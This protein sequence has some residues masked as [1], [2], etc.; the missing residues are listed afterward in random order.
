M[1]AVKEL[2]QWRRD[3]IAAIN[4]DT[5]TLKARIQC[6]EKLTGLQQYEALESIADAEYNLRGDC[7]IV[8]RKMDFLN[9]HLGLDDDGL[10]DDEAIE[11][12]SRVKPQASFDQRKSEVARIKAKRVHNRIVERVCNLCGRKDHEPH[13]SSCNG[14]DQRW[15]TR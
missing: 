8:G 15:V 10:T 7:D 13:P 12:A 4:R 14:P 1:I 5:A 6:A 9:V 2:E 3:T 11:L